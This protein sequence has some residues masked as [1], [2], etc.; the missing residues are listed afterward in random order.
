MPQANFNHAKH[1]SIKCDDCHHAMRSRETSDVLMPVKANCVTCH[2]PAG[3]V[4]AE[5]ITCHTY[6][7]Q[8][9]AMTADASRV[10]RLSIKQMLLGSDAAD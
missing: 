10:S 9:P 1:A 4:V 2:S 3:K 8:P 5:C 7:G 6:H